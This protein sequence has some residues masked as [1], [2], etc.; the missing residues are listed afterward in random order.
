MLARFSAFLYTYARKRNKK[1][2][3]RGKSPLEIGFSLV[4]RDYLSAVVQSALHHLDGKVPG[5]SPV[6][7][8][9]Y[10]SLVS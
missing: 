1:K 5:V 4:F 7:T 2:G 10:Q 3:L 8:G 9:D 6:D